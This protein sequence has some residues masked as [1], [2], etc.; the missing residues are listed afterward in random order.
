MVGSGERPLRMVA[1]KVIITFGREFSHVACCES[2]LFN[3]S[4]RFRGYVMEDTQ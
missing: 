3:L 2:A 4:E 1:M